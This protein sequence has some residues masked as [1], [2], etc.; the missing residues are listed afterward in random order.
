ML[1]LLENSFKTNFPD[2]AK[3]IM[4]GSGGFSFLVVDK[5]GSNVLLNA[6]SVLSISNNLSLQS[7]VETYT[8]TTSPTGLRASGNNTQ[9]FVEYATSDT[10]TA[11]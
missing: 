1:R 5:G 4:S 2:G 11:R 8:L 6:S 7:G 3:L 9:T 10:M